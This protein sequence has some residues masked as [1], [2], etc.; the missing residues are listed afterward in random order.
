VLLL[1][2]ACKFTPGEFGGGSG[3]GSDGGTLDGDGAVVMADA[4]PDT[5]TPDWAYRRVITINNAGLGAL[6]DFTV[7]VTLDATKIRYTA[8]GADLRFADSGGTPLAYEIETWNTSGSSYVWV[9]IPAIA[10]NTTTTFQ[11]F[12]GNPNATDAQMAAQTWDASYAGVWHL[13]DAHDSTTQNAS[14]N[15]GGTAT[16]G[17]VG[18]ALAFDGA[19]HYVDTGEADN[20]SRWT[21]E[22]WMKPAA[23]AAATGA[24]SVL[25]RFNNYMILWSCA[26]ATFCSTVM[27][28]GSQTA[29][30]YAGYTATV[31]QWSYIVGRYNGSSLTAVTNGTNSNNSGTNDDPI[32][33]AATAKIGSR[34]DL[35]G[36]FVGS[37][38]E[39]RISTIGRSNDY[40]Q[41]QYK[42]MNGTY[43]TIG[44][45]LAN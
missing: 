18:G 6:A 35:A 44:G 39:V 17:Q 1:L 15:V 30:H 42:S 22:A 43:L 14:T 28:Q 7:L 5:I 2:A 33:E 37:V 32:S 10:A 27:Y 12:Y 36:D 31:N 34:Q 3:S 24:Q 13:V 8:Q 29:T 9:R 41:A 16:T 38:D 45:E 11:M 40:I 21:I 25:S 4:A 20:L 23:A 26:N 19:N